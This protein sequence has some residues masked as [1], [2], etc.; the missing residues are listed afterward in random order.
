M[1]IDARIIPSDESIETDVCI[2]GAGPAGISLARELAGQDFRVCLLESGGFEEPDQAMQELADVESDGQFVQVTPTNR[3]R[4]FGGNSS[5]WAINLKH[6]PRGIRLIPLFETDFEP[7]D[8]LPYSGWP[9]K[10]EHLIPY[11]KRAQEVFGSGPYAYEA[12]DWATA[13]AP[14]LPLKGSRAKTSIFQFG[15]GALF[16]REYRTELDRAPNITT[17][18]YANALELDTDDSGQTVNRVQVGTLNGNRFWISAKIVILAAGGVESTHLLM[19]SNRVHQN[20]IGN[21]HDLLGRFFMD[22]PII[23]GG[24]IVPFDRQIFNRTTLYDL[25]DVNGTHVMGGLTLTDEVMRREKLLNISCWIFPRAKR[26]RSSDAMTSLK[27][28]ASSQRFE[29][30]M[31]GFFQDLGKVATGI[32]DIAASISDKIRRKQQPFWPTMALG[33]WSHLQPNRDK[34]YGV[35]EVVHMVEQVPNPDNRLRLGDGIDRLGRR[36]IRLDSCWREAD[37]QGI[38]R[39]QAVL[40]EELERS[41]I[42]KFVIER[43]EN[44]EL[45]VS[46]LGASHHM[47]TTRMHDDPKQGVVDANCR[48]HGVSN[49]F[50]ASSS[51]FPTGSCANPTLTIVALSLR[52]ADQVKAMMAGNVVAAKL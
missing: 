23:H 36:K 8:W 47:G 29:Q 32:D 12:E 25:R 18:T 19:L 45:I 48:V 51:V 15:D 14:Q 39:A 44:G 4:R 33:G 42:G 31:G 11:Y 13:E 21:Q 43:E 7:R 6:S 30:G 26:F 2:V 5:Y 41:G 17:Y 28:L 27:R 49:L 52:I 35:F 3:N 50:I 38:N 9:F 37:L 40:A 46:T 1:I 16:T 24:L 22:H 10:R 34:E 20:G